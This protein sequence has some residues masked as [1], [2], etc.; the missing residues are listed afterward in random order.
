MNL[1][2]RVSKLPNLKC[3]SELV[4]QGPLLCG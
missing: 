4:P 1:T 3:K 2:Q